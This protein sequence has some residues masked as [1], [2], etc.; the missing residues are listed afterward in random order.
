MNHR[1]LNPD[2]ITGINRKARQS[3]LMLA[4][5]ICVP[6]WS[7]PAPLID[8]VPRD[9][10]WAP[11]PVYMQI[12]KSCVGYTLAAW[13][14]AAP[15]SIPAHASGWQIYQ[16]AQEQ[17]GIA[18]PHEGTTVEAGLAVLSRL[19]YARDWQATSDPARALAFLHADGPIV[20]LSGFPDGPAVLDRDG[21]LTWTGTQSRHAW[22]CYS[23]DAGDRLGCQNSESSA[24]NPSERGR[25]HMTRAALAHALAQGRAWL[26][27]KAPVAPAA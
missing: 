24:W 5:L 15:N 12:G 14:D 1:L 27:H 4:V 22:L 21:N 18:G 11:G 7:I 17:D 25:F 26:I 23:V 13:L 19:G 3:L 9:R 6:A 16:A 2:L 20:I 10:I 8:S